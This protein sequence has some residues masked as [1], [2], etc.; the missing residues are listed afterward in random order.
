LSKGFG[1]KINGL[2]VPGDYTLDFSVS[3]S[4]NT[5]HDTL[6][7]P[8]Y[9][10]NENAPEIVSMTATK[11]TVFLPDCNVTL[12]A[13]T[14][15]QDGDGITHWWTLI[16][17]PEGAKPVLKTPG[18]AQT[19]VSDMKIPGYYRFL[20][21]AI[22]RTLFSYDDI[23]VVVEDPT[24]INDKTGQPA[25]ISVNPNPASDRCLIS[26]RLNKPEVIKLS[27]S[28]CLGQQISILAD[29]YYQQGDYTKTFDTRNIPSGIYFYKLQAGKRI[30]EGKIVVTK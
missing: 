21:Y 11:D 15:D 30:L 1:W 29:G 5:V 18:L 9:P 14:F 28:N 19:L 24:Y 2:S 6:V 27:I 22:D 7:I 10:A 17:A 4:I 12:T 13:E 25:S 8:V 16:S 3:D 26:F 20:L 23:T